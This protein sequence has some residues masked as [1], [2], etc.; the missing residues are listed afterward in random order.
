MI[1][2]VPFAE[3]DFIFEEN[4]SEI[5]ISS[6]FAGP[7]RSRCALAPQ[8]AFPAARPA[9]SITAATGRAA[10]PRAP[11]LPARPGGCAHRGP[12]PDPTRPARPGQARP[13]AL[14]RSR[15]LGPSAGAEGVR[16]LRRLSL[17]QRAPRERL[18]ACPRPGKEESRSR[19]PGR[20]PGPGPGPQ[21]PLPVT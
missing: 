8:I 14:A 7:D 10:L 12:S 20:A 11:A 4:S 16:V 1:T 17:G 21:S 2:N 5:L 18:P 15:A 19:A 9:P 6:H 13:G 3:R